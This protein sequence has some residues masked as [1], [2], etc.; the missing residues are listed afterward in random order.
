MLRVFP[1]GLPDVLLIEP[2][3]FSDDR[4]FLF[5]SFNASEFADLT[6][7]HHQFVQD[8]HSRSSKNVLR[9]LHYQ[10][11]HSQGKLIRV[12][13][14]EIWDVTVD[15]RRSSPAFGRWIGLRLSASNGRHLWIPPGFAHGFLV[16]CDRT[17]VLYKC[18]EY[19][20][21]EWERCIRWN[22]A[23][24]AIEWP[25]QGEPRLSPK[26]QQGVTFTS[27]EVFP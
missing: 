11:Q 6:G 26:D 16:L 12:I 17:D 1:A 15:L 27:S 25:L 23:D 9:G 3:V 21:P 10:I 20:A 8:V 19:Y 7:A 4:G 18:T 22:D 5:E 13:S 14:G 2:E 24:L